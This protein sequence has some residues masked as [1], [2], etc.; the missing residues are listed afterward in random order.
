MRRTG[1]VKLARSYLVASCMALT[2]LSLVPVV[3]LHDPMISL[4]FLAAAMFFNEMN[5]GPMWAIPMDVAYDRSGTASGIMSGTGFTA[6]IV[7]PVIA[8]LVADRLRSW[9]L[10]FVL[11][12]GVML[13][14]IVLSFFMKPNIPFSND[15]TQPRSESQRK[16]DAMSGA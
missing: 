6:A 11:S 13:F 10:T 1:N 8:G 2:A 12:I 5:V 3:L 14:G 15:A 16:E 4:I 7:S 9:D